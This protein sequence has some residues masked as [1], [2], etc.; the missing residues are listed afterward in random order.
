MKATREDV[1]KK[2]GVSV[3]TVSCVLNKSR[4]VSERTIQKVLQAVEELNYKPD[5]IA[6]S[7]V[8]NETKQISVVVNDIENPFFGEII[9]G[10]E[11][12]AIEKGYFINVCTGFKNLDEYFENFV[13]RRIDG[14][15]I[16]AIP[17]KFHIDKVYNLVS[18]NI[19]V[20]V[21]GNVEADFR[22]V[23]SIECDHYDGMKQAFEHLT[24]LGHI[25]IAFI[26]GLGEIE[27]YQRKCEGY[28]KCVDEF[29]LSCGNTLLIDGSE[30]FSTKYQDGYNLAN[31]LITSKKNFT[32]VICTNDLMAIGAISAFKGAG[33]RIPEDVSVVGFDGIK[34]GEFIDPPLTTLSIE[35]NFFGRRTFELL[36]HNIKT[37]STGFYLSQYK[38]VV[39]SSTGR[40]RG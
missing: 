12:A 27:H 30:P 33:I 40:C 2:A 13:A 3:A 35:K 39:R 15:F 20:V 16:A 26:N 34:T 11:N 14:V 31:K 38:L 22:K 23:S 21:S 9:S 6:L 25:D 7:M 17:N 1:A 19:K 28:L 4:R 36:Y 10:F 18:S 5:M 32:A 29:K 24:G 8:K 37:G